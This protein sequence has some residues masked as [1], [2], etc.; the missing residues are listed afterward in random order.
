MTLYRWM[1][2]ALF[3]TSLTACPKE[4]EPL[5]GAEAQEAMEEAAFASEAEALTAEEIEI[6]TDFTLGEGARKAAENIRDF[7]QSQAPCADVTLQDTTVV[8][9][10]GVEE[11]CTWRGRTWHGQ[12]SVAITKAEGAEVEVLHGWTGFTNGR[13]TLDGTARVTWS[14]AQQ[15]R[16]VEHD[17]T[18]TR[19]E[20]QARGTGDRTQTLL[21]PSQ[22]IAGGIAIEGQRTWTG[23]TGSTW[24]LT[25]EGVEARPQDPVPQAGTYTLDTPKGKQL[26][27][28]FERVDAARIRVTMSSGDRDFSFIVLASGLVQRAE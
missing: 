8:V 1:A 24:Y 7:Y 11:G 14:L 15:S 23:P 18:W 22:G 2:P 28:A 27:L 3:L 5:T 4:E 19:G 9:D 10:F 6:S 12:H 17:F 16:R 26:T 25:I 13:I 21:D 20:K